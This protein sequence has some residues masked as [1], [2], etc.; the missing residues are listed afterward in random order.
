M[1]TFSIHYISTLDANAKYPDFS[2]SL[3]FK[4]NNKSYVS[5]LPP[6]FP[7]LPIKRQVIIEINIC[8]TYAINNF[9]NIEQ[10]N[11]LNSILSDCALNDIEINFEKIEEILNILECKYKNHLFGLITDKENLEY[12][13]KREFYRRN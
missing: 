3:L 9:L 5:L 2:E 4:A 6:V 7:P 11:I 12:R 1:I 13:T 10:R 8:F